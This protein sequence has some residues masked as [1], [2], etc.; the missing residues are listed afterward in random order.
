VLIYHADRI[1]A[2]ALEDLRRAGVA[3]WHLGEPGAG[4]DAATARLRR[5]L[6]ESRLIGALADLVLSR[7]G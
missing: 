4:E 6:T 2:G 7:S 5:P 1:G 3:C